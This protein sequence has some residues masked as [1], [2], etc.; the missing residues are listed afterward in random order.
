MQTA[1]STFRW[2]AFVATLI[3]TY[4][5]TTTNTEYQW[6]GWFISF[7]STSMWVY[8]AYKDGD[9]PRC[10]MEACF[11]FLCLKLNL[12]QKCSTKKFLE[13]YV[14]ATYFFGFWK[15]CFVLKH[16]KKLYH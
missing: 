12:A 6:I 13:K 8:C 2:L 14:S 7:L 15:V 5:L 3:G 16:K 4:I 9:I 11:I 10:T 1:N